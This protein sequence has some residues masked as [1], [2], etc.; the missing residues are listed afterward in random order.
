MPNAPAK[1]GRS[2]ID[3]RHI[4]RHD[5]DGHDGC[6]KNCSGFCG[7]AGVRGQRPS[8]TASKAARSR[9]RRRNNSPVAHGQEP[10]VAV[11]ITVADNL[12]RGRVEQYDHARVIGVEPPYHRR[13]WPGQ[14]G[15]EGLQQPTKASPVV[16]TSR[17][18]RSLDR[19][20]HL[21]V[22]HVEWAALAATPAVKRSRHC[23]DVARRVGHRRIRDWWFTVDRVYRPTLRRLI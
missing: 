2:D 20:D 17:W 23:G 3:H 15:V 10:R 5:H 16:P 13:E 18:R 21:I 4:Y 22:Q 19:P 8:R 14:I 1:C 7:R 6:G 12:R 9:S 11:F